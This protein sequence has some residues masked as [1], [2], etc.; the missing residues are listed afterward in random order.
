[1]LH[2]KVTSIS[3]FHTVL[4]TT[5]K[6]FSKHLCPHT[7]LPSCTQMFHGR[8]RESVTDATRGFPRQTASGEHCSTHARNGPWPCGATQASPQTVLG[9]ACT[10]SAHIYE[11]GH[12][13]SF[14]K[15]FLMHHKHKSSLLSRTFR[16][17]YS[18]A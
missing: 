12:M 4:S 17:G 14:T 11:D 7:R 13:E 5:E 16:T 2:T 6:S 8:E 10:Y 15:A 18:F 1:M 9:A 3:T